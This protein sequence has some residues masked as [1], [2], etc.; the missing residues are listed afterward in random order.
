MVFKFH[1][2]IPEHLNFLQVISTFNY[3]FL[4]GGDFVQHYQFIY[5]SREPNEIF[6]I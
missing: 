4:K 6:V 1:I 2:N 3:V 5:Q